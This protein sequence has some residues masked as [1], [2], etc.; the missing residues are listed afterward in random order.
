MTILE[1]PESQALLE[2]ATIRVEQLEEL[3]ERL[4]PFLQRYLPLF[5]REEQRLHARFLMQGKLSPLKRKTAEPIAHLFGVRREN[6]QDFLGVSPWQDR[7]ILDELRRHVIEVWGD[8]NGVLSGDGSDFPKKGKHSCGVK[9]QHCGRLGKVENCQAGIFLGYSCKHGHTLLEHR[10]FLP[11]EW[12]ADPTLRKETKVPDDIVYKE[13]WEILLDEIDLAK[14]VPHAW[15][16]AD[17]EFGR[18]NEFRKGLRDRN[19]RYVVDVRDDLRLRDLRAK[20]PERKGTTGRIPRV[21]ATTNASAWAAEQPASAWQRILIRDGEKMP[22]IVE[23]AETWVETFEEHTRVGPEER[24][25]VIRTVDNPDPKTWYTLS[26]AAETVPLAEVAWGHAQRYWQEASFEDGKGEVGMAHYEVRSWV[27]WHHHMTLSLL[28]LWFL[29]AENQRVQKKTPAMTASTL[30]EAFGQMMAL[31]ELTL[32]GIAR[33]VNATLRRKE[34]ARIYH[35]YQKTG[36]Y[37]P[38]RGQ[39]VNGTAGAQE[40]GLRDPPVVKPL[41]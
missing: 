14:D 5:Q 12:A 18:V 27:G 34:E 19:E 28:A 4:E 33:A 24:F 32:E 29:V 11:P 8:P 1:H 25:V 40:V 30:Q 15:I 6:L 39:T 7:L 36:R 3:G 41:Q 23:A 2:D 35:Y 21:P 38:R 13:R 16:V 20:P 31:R 26:N 9:R 22:L 17:A 10:L 37:P